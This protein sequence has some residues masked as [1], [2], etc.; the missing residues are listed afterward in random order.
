MNEAGTED[1]SLGNLVRCAGTSRRRLGGQLVDTLAHGFRTFG[2]CRSWAH[3]VDS[4][5]ARAIIQRT[6][7][8][9]H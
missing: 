3:R 1:D 8:L 9:Y 2:A 5:T 6:T 7:R 4:D